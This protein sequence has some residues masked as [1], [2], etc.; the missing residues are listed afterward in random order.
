MVSGPFLKEKIMRP[1]DEQIKQE[2]LNG[3]TIASVCKNLKTHSQR[4]MKVKHKYGL[5]CK[6]IGIY[7]GGCASIWKEGGQ[8][9]ESRYSKKDKDQFGGWY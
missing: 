8:R 2:L 3:G 7:G 4:V 6:V 1:T 5:E 9:S